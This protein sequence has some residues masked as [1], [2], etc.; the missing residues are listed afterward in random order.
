MTK[1]RVHGLSISLDGYGAGP[2]QDIDNP[3]GIGGLALHDWIIHTRTFQQ[4]EGNGQKTQRTARMSGS[5]A[6]SVRFGN[7]L[8]P[9]SLTKC[10]LRSVRSFSAQGNICSTAST[11]WSWVISVPST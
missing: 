4:L 5:V 11:C 7:T 8:K 2:E 3:L 6:A 1:L 10:T 9:D